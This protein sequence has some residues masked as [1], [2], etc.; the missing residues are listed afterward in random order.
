[1]MQILGVILIVCSGIFGIRAVVLL[2]KTLANSPA[3]QRS[4][5]RDEQFYYGLIRPTQNRQF[6]LSVFICMVSGFIGVLLLSLAS[7]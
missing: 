3:S 2:L 4:L 5:S 7:I 6:M 1:M